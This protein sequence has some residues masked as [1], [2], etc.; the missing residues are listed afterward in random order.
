MN[1]TSTSLQKAEKAIAEAE[2]VLIGGGAGLSTA[3]GLDYSGEEFKRR[4]FDFIGKYGFT[5]LYTSS[6][7]PF[8]NE[9]VKWA[10]WARH[11]DMARFA[12]PAMPLYKSLLARVKDKKYFVI[13]TN[14]DGQFIKAGFDPEKVFEVQGDYGKMQCATACH[15]K[16]YSDEPVVR[17]ILASGCGTEAPERLVPHCPVCG[18]PMDVN[19]RVNNYFIEDERWHRLAGKYYDFVDEAKDRKLVLLEYG[20][21]YNTPSIIRFPFE[22]MAASFPDTTLIRVNKDYPHPNVQGIKRLIMLDSL[23]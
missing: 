1:F 23:D 5:D 4:F 6:F 7:Y 14:V 2:Y 20:V 15:P 21:G 13:T 18:G 22:Q 8:P 12:P 16:L 3:A 10:Y 11:I 9:G 17:D 19:V